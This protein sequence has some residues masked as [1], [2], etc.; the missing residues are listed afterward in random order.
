M[1]HNRTVLCCCFLVRIHS[2][3]KF[4]LEQVTKAQR[5][6][7][8]STL[9]LT[10]ALDGGGWSTPHPGRLPPEK[11]R[12]PFYR[13]LGWPR[14][15]YKRVGKILPPTG[16]RSPD[17]PARSES[18]YRLSYPVAY[19]HIHIYPH[20]HSPYQWKINYVILKFVDK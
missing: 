11:T 10:A 8:S 14:G 20:S 2:H 13:R 17:S 3:H 9:S 4:T 7:Y 16:I 5:G 15:R 12:Y 18:L 6:S 19:P 1:K